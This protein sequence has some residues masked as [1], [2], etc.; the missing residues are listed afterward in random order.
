M[1]YKKSNYNIVIENESQ[2]YMFNS[3]TLACS[4]FTGKELQLYNEIK[5]GKEY[6][7]NFYE[8]LNQ[9]G[10]I[11]NNELDEKKIL[12]DRLNRYRYTKEVLDITLAPTLSCNFKCP[13]CFEHQATKNNVGIMDGDIQREV[14]E[15]IKIKLDGSKKL[16]I[17]WYGGEPLLALSAIRNISERLITYCDN[18]KIEYSASIITNGYLLD[19]IEPN[20]FKRYKIKDM[21]VTIDGNEEV[22]NKRRVLRSGKG[23]YKQILNNLRKHQNHVQIIVRINIDRQN[24]N[25]IAELLCDLKKYDLTEIFLDA[26]P[27]R[28]ADNLKDK[29]CFSANEFEKVSREIYS[30][31]NQLG[32]KHGKKGLIGTANYCLAD[33]VNSYVIDNNGYLYK[34]SRDIGNYKDSLGSILGDKISNTAIYYEYMAYDPTEDQQCKE[35]TLLPICMGGCPYER[36]HHVSRCNINIEEVK[37]RIMDKIEI[38]ENC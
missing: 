1:K 22:H 10:Y 11:L 17:A 25:Q 26:A 9:C 16:H 19:S 12:K 13:Y 3:R 28:N 38:H 35:C 21:Q 7:S 32:I 36:I 4:S 27:V 34:C 33:S 30:M 18:N 23:T 5:D 20:F 29:I 31:C 8:E 15:F 6:D 37:K 14:V 2:I 24:S